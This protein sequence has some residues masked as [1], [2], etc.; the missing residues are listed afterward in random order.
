[1]A[2]A[3][4]SQCG[5]SIPESLPACLHCRSS[6]GPV[7]AA[8]A[9]PVAPSGDLLETDSGS[10]GLQSSAVVAQHPYFPVAIHKFIVLSICTLTIYELYWSYQQWQRIRRATGEELR[11]F[12]RAFFAPLWG[13]SLFDRIRDDALERN[14]PAAW[15]APLLG[16]IYLLLS[17]AWRLPDPIWLV[18]LASFLPLIPVVRTVARINASA[19]AAEGTNSTYSALNII[20]IVV[21]GILLLLAIAGSFIDDPA[22]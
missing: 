15:N 14:L 22:V 17:V 5:R 16:T 10:V 20:T 8:A 12:W 21:G 9:A 4:C 1:M 6:A 3:I 19:P 11:P 13:F 7:T 18:S 2:M